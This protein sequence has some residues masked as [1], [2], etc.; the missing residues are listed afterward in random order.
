MK[1]IYILLIIT[2]T[3]VS[4][5]RQQV[6]NIKFKKL[7]ID[8]DKHN[9]QSLNKFNN[10][11][12]LVLESGQNRL[13]LYNKNTRE[14][15]ICELTPYTKKYLTT[16]GNIIDITQDY[17]IT[18]VDAA[19]ISEFLKGKNEYDNF[20]ENYPEQI[21]RMREEL[22]DIHEDSNPCIVIYSI[23]HYSQSS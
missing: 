1:T 3:C 2:I 19:D 13:C 12:Y 11:I 10:Y 20:E 17:I 16:F 9:A 23:Q 6:E 15:S 8:F 4:C 5:Q 21:Q 18:S 14:A 22:P 7:A